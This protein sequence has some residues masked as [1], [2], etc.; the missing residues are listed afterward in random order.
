MDKE[1]LIEQARAIKKTLDFAYEHNDEEGIN[2][3]ERRLAKK[4]AEIHIF[5]NKDSPGIDAR[6]NSDVCLAC[7]INDICLCEFCPIKDGK[8]LVTKESRDNEIKR[9]ED[10][11]RSKD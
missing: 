2:A 3:L 9:L 6:L 11:I 1:G 4:N 7:D 5:G 10:Q 8:M